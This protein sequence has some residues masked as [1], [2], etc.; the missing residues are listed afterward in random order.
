[1]K[2]LIVPSEI[3]RLSIELV[4]QIVLRKMNSV[5]GSRLHEGKEIGSVE[6]TMTIAPYIELAQ[7]RLRHALVVLSGI[8]I[9]ALAAIVFVLRKK[10]LA[11]IAQLTHAA[12]R[13]ADE[14]LTMPISMTGED[15]LGRV[16][17]A[18]ESMR[19]RLLET[20]GKLNDLAFFDQLTGLPNRGY[21]MERLKQVL[22][23][24][25]RN[26]NF[27]AVL[28]IDLD[29][30]KI[31][32]DTKGHDMGDSLLKH[33]ADRLKKC[34]RGD[35]TVARL[36][37]DEFVVVLSDLGRHVEKAASA[38]ELVAEKILWELSQPCLIGDFVHRCTAS[39]GATVFDAQQMVIDDV[40][41]Q[42]DLAM[43]R[44]KDSGRDSI[45]FFD[46]ALET[47][48]RVKAEIEGDL[49]QA[50]HENQ[51]ELHY[52]ALLLGDGR[53]T[54]AEALIRWQHPG[55]EMMSPAEF[56]PLA[57]ESD[58]I[59]PLGR[60]VLET[61][62]AQLAAWAD[63]PEMAPLT[64]SVNVSPK[65]FRQADF[66]DR[67]LAALSASGANPH[68]LKL[69]LT[70]SLF[71]DDLADIAWKMSALKA[72][73]IGFS[74]DDFGTG[75]SSLTYLKRLP[76]DQLKIDRTFVRDLLTDPDDAAIARTV[77]ALAKSLGL[78]VIAEGVETKEQ[79]DFLAALNCYAYQGYFFSRPLTIEQFEDYL[80]R[81]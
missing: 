77:V 75:Y 35:D 55:G 52:Q 4:M 63:R 81:I 22:A 57:E 48:V 31:L 23:M 21:L 80:A 64:I 78:A 3:K 2:L 38:T 60:W 8:L 33:T 67:V 73:G 40:L 25:S 51:F 61:A 34:V 16:A 66:V 68:C 28:F 19:Q 46:P 50:V 79:R 54:G 12:H 37:G 9:A 5:P 42:A 59:V 74:L 39:I 30:F 18:M 27:G 44:A 69:E 45:C 14:N 58:L 47:A 62:C 24:N 7:T 71:V 65:Q 41:K 72:K 15:E 49:R 29:N 76:F 20:F 43:Y 1:M 70:E 32:N 17:G 36:G 10:L 6:V 11:P 56:I 13:I 26:G 53:V